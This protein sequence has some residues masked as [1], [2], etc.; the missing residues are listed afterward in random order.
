MSRAITAGQHAR[1]V[2][3]SHL[4][5]GAS[6]PYAKEFTTFAKPG[7][8][9]ADAIKRYMRARRAEWR[10]APSR[11]FPKSADA[12]A[13]TKAYVEA[14]YRMNFTTEMQGY[15]GGSS[16][17]VRDLFGELSTAPTTW[18]ETDEVEVDVQVCETCGY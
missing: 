15:T 5:P 1:I 12:L 8:S 18:P 2:M 14:Y 11:N 6:R 10:K 7:E 17:F 4:A 3:A 9:Q 13:N 16:A